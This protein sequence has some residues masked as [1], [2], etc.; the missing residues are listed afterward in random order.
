[1]EV[2]PGQTCATRDHSRLRPPRNRPTRTGGGINP[3]K[4]VEAEHALG[5]LRY[6]PAEAKPILGSCLPRRRQWPSSSLSFPASPRRSKPR[7][8]RL[9]RAPSCSIPSPT[10]GSRPGCGRSWR[11]WSRR[12]P[13]PTTRSGPQRRGHRLRPGRHVA[14]WPRG[15]RRQA[16]AHHRAHGL[17]R[18]GR[19]ASLV[20]RPAAAALGRRRDR[21]QCRAR[22]ARQLPDPGSRSRQDTRGLNPQRHITESTGKPQR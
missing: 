1:M 12:R 21:G 19:G 11:W 8:R 5:T 6:L 13:A 16:R 17:L 22:R 9:K 15:R 14:G 2:D 7:L 10:A 18:S 3:P 20:T 4:G